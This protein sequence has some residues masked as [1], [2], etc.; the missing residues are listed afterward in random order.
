MSKS[1]EDLRSRN[2]ISDRASTRKFVGG[3]RVNS[4]TAIF[5]RSLGMGIT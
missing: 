1:Q 3:D 4:I 5:A 2:T